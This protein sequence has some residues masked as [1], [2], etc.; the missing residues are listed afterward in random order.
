[1]PQ[2]TPAR[3]AGPAHPV[4]SGA[5]SVLAGARRGHAG[6]FWLSVALLALAVVSAVGVVVD[7]RVVLG[8]PVWLKPLK[9]ALSFAL[10]TAALAWMLSL[11]D[12][13]R[14][15]GAV[16]GWV[17]AI[18]SAAELAIITGQAA[19]GVR[20]HFNESTPVDGLLF[21]IMGLTVAVIWVATAALALVVLRRPRLDRPIA[22]AIRLGLL[23]AL[24]G[25]LVGVVMSVNGGHAVGVADGGAGL[26]L[27]GWSTTGGDLRVG[28]FVGMHALQ[29]LPLLAALLTAVAARGPARGLPELARLRLVRLAAAGYLGL[30]LLLVWQ[31]LRGQPVTAPDAATLAALGAL[32]AA[33]AAGTA[34]ILRRSAA[35]RPQQG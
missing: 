5:S 3:V 27:S 18:G 33:V 23:V 26:P 17:I 20:S 22:S 8:A 13:R 19:R 30:L 10:Y 31:A 1:M 9:F 21:S 24:L 25:M 34:V 35:E 2:L 12:A 32:L 29:V 15:T 11:V 16:L 4:R 7:D 6:L 14:R 28:H